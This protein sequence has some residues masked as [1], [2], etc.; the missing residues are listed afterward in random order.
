MLNLI[1]DKICLASQ[2]RSGSGTYVRDGFIY[3]SLVGN[4]KIER[5]L[6][7]SSKNENNKSSQNSLLP[8][9]SIK[10]IKDNFVVIPHVGS[11]VIAK[12]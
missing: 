11:L 1:G 8:L 9:V 6:N 5:E 4:A 10:T 12:V 2:A 7:T 3:A